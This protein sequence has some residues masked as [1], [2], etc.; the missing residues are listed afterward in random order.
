MQLRWL[1]SAV[2]RTPIGT[3]R[4][5]SLPEQVKGPLCSFGLCITGVG[6]GRP[7]FGAMG[8]GDVVALDNPV[9]AVQGDRVTHLLY[10]VS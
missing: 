6:S 9:R 2:T 3:L 10:D 4:L 5:R 1:Y 8:A 7:F